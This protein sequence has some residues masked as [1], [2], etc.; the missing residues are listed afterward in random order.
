MTF[1]RPA[2]RGPTIFGHGTQPL[3]GHGGLCK[4]YFHLVG[5][6]A[7][8]DGVGIVI[9]YRG[10]K[11]W[12]TLAPARLGC[13]AWK[14]LYLI[15]PHMCYQLPCRIWSLYTGYCQTL[16]LYEGVPKIMDYRR[17]RLRQNDCHN[18]IAFVPCSLSLHLS[19]YC[20]SSFISPCTCLKGNA[21]ATQ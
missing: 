6:H 15:I 5:H 4:I 1:K 8:F 3:R 13:R 16:G 7:K 21:A 14:T 11:N 17:F 12:G 2:A 20:F 18:A 10:S 19:F 9:T